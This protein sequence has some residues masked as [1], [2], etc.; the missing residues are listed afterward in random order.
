MP[1]TSPM[2]LGSAI[3][4]PWGVF[5]IL[6]LVTFAAHL[7]VMNVALG[8][9][10]LAFFLPG[11][12]RKTAG[13]LAGK[14]PTSVAVTVNLG[15][16]PLLFASVLYG[17]YLYTAAILSAVTWVSFFLVVMLAY[18]LLYRFQPRALTPGAAWLAA[19][20]AG[21]L[22]AAS[23]IMTNVATLSVRP[24]AWKAAAIP[25]GTL[26]NWADPT[27]FPRWLHFVLAS[28]AVAGLFLALVSRRAAGRGDAAARERERAGLAVFTRATLA[29]I[30]VGG[31]FLWT[32]PEAVRGLFLGGDPGATSVLALGLVLAGM[33][34]WQGWR[35]AAA[36]TAA[37]A[38]A[39]VCFMTVVRELARRAELAPHFAPGDLPVVFQAGPFVLF[40]V[41][42]V[43]VAGGIA[44]VVAVYRRAAGRG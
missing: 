5:E 15:I 21:L 13:V 11:P 2:A 9:A 1:A 8:G 44:W 22:L 28:L 29:Q 12:D 36:R 37:Y 33:A 32:L 20:A 30:A 27:F 39:T 26:F 25:G 35:G 18:A 17:Q 10:L 34:V 43:V 38:V 31:L 4:A 14:L 40:V 23:A 6:L 24:E 7:L 16:P 42:A 3:T 19:L 41:S